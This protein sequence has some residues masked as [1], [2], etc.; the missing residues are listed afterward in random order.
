[1]PSISQI[2]IKG[3]HNIRFQQ[4]ISS[5]CL[6]TATSLHCIYL[7]NL[8]LHPSIHSIFPRI[9]FVYYSSIILPFPHSDF[10]SL[11]ALITKSISFSIVSLCCSYTFF[12]RLIFRC[13]LKTTPLSTT[14]MIINKQVIA[15]AQKNHAF[16]EI[17]TN[18]TDVLKFSSLDG[19][20]LWM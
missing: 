10:V 9:L 16:D 13:K 7:Y 4:S 15:T 14:I 17:S 19:C 3:Q 8:P 20:R 2:N 5:F 6:N 1:M 12:V 11:S 18:D